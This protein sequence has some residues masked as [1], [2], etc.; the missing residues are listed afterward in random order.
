MSTCGASHPDF[1]VRCEA[2]EGGHEF[3]YA[4]PQW[5]WDNP[6][7]QVAAARRARMHP[8]KRQDQMTKIAQS[9]RKSRAET[10]R[11]TDEGIANAAASA[12]PEEQERW[13]DAVYRTA[14]RL[15]AFLVDEVWVTLGYRPDRAVAMG[16][17]MRRA[18]SLGWIESSGSTDPTAI[19][20]SH[21]ERR[22]WRS[23]IYRG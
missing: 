19:I 17:V 11:V 10:D 1:D 3:H 16:A 6:E 9:V 20:T 14:L 13:L 23:L 4:A 22:L 21:S 18:A 12:D 15:E 8:T 7:G 5:W 2:P